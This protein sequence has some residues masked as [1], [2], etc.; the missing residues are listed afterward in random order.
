MEPN[1][2]SD[3]CKEIFALLS[4]HL[5]LELQPEACQEIEDHIAG[6]PPCIEFTESL[7]KTV[8][9]CRQCPAN[10]APPMG[11]ETKAHLMEAYGKMLASRADQDG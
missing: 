8:D 2:H 9:L 1:R 5:D 6:C 3:K 7:R 10:G 11:Q 4:D